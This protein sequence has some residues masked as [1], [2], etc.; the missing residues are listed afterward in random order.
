VPLEM[1]RH[2]ETRMEALKAQAV[3]ARTYAVKRALAR[4]REVFDLHASAQEQ[5]YG[6]AGAGHAVSDRA[7]REAAGV[8]RLYGDS[9]AH[10]YYHST[11]G[12]RTASRHEVWGGERIPY[13]ITA[14]DA[15][16]AGEPW[17][18]ASRYMSWTQTWD[19]DALAAIARRNMAE[20]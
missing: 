13:L 20:A 12:G 6:G 10:T 11:C 7:E 8:R 19:A 15:D 18:R 9:R 2:D 4:P 1:G 3:A 5:V 16:S 14:P 17:C